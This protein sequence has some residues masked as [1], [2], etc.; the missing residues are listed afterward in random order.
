MSF[1]QFVNQVVV[2]MV[3]G[4]IMPLLYALAFLFFIFGV[5]RLFFSASDE[6]REQG[7][8]FALWGIIGLVVMF[9]VWGIVKI[10]LR[11]LTGG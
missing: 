11:V 6:K 1:N 4:Y 7:R 3:D 2:G 9:A 5:A 8:Q 10:F